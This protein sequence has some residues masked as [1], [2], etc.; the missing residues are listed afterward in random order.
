M[1]DNLTRWSTLLQKLPK[2]ITTLGIIT[3]LVGYYILWNHD[4]LAAI[5][6]FSPNVIPAKDTFCN[7]FHISILNKAKLLYYST[8]L[9]GL[10]SILTK[11]F[12]PEEP[13]IFKNEDSYISRCS[14]VS[15]KS[16]VKFLF[17]NNI[18]Q[19]RFANKRKFKSFK[20]QLTS[21][22][23]DIQDATGDDELKLVCEFRKWYF[24]FVDYSIIIV[25]IIN[26][27]LLIAFFL[28]GISSLSVFLS[29]SCMTI[30]GL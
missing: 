21:I 6:N 25:P 4:I 2:N 18:A 15:N 14:S 26:S 16:D 1:L 17:I 8:F 22:F 23:E 11:S 9:F 10:A 27:L 29:I 5:H 7:V 12:S 3:A 24:R 20:S 13:S 19:R 28:V 30:Q